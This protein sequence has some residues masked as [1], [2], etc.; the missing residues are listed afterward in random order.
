MIN[1]LLV[2]FHTCKNSILK[3][4]IVLVAGTFLTL[5]DKIENKTGGS[6]G[7]A[8]QSKI[9][10][11]GMLLKGDHARTRGYGGSPAPVSLERRVI[12]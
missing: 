1:E 5:I 3:D 11:T 8:P 6:G 12:M 10:K 4:K 7:L 2:I 9:P